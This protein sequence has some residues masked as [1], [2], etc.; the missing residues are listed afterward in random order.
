LTNNLFLIDSFFEE[1][2]VAI[3]LNNNITQFYILY[4]LL[5]YLCYIFLIFNIFIV[6]FRPNI[7]S[8][9]NIYLLLYFSVLFCFFF[10]VRPYYDWS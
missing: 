5:Y 10:N 4:I 3:M 9:E 6:V 1:F 7:F 2:N 8:L